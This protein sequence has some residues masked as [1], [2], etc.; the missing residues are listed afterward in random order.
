MAS[1]SDL[2]SFFEE[3]QTQQ[4]RER[5]ARIDTVYLWDVCHEKQA[6]RRT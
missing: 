4:E 1:F 5:E 6:E 2:D 3:Q